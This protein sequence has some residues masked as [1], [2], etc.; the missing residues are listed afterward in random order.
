[1]SFHRWAHGSFEVFYKEANGELDPNGEPYETGWYWWPCWPGCL[2][3]G[4]PMGPYESERE[5]I[6]YAQ[7]F[8]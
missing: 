4:D 7:D 3:D 8:G 6:E 1:M 5:A 2:P